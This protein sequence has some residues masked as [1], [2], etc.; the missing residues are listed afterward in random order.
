MRTRRPAEVAEA[1]HLAFLTA[2]AAVAD[3]RSFALK[4]GG[5]L[6]FFFG[7][8]RFSEDIDLDAFAAEP[9]VFSLKVEKA[10]ES[11]NLA[12]L[13]ATLGIRV[14][15]L[16][17]KDRTSTKEKWVIGLSHPGVGAPV[18]TRV[19]ISHR[20]YGLEA[21][22][23]V[24]P[25]TSQAVA[26]YA[27]LPAPLIGHYL[28]GG[29]VIQKIV[30]LQG[31][32]ATQPRDVFDLDHLFRR[33][34]ETVRPSVLDAATLE[35]AIARVYE[36]DSAAYRSKVVSFLDPS[37]RAALDTADAWGSMQ[38]RVVEALEAMLP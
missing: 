2:F 9:G 12:K 15:H 13:L 6:R 31:R 10:F 3:P 37:V 1:F 22:V 14:T 36:I 35:A 33:Y 30:A 4:G 26:A 18:Y 28:P 5:N 34:P 11:L 32:R 38:V 29:A 7:S 16:N 27:P 19:E 20:A 25:V 8:L 23:A 17:P 24:E 21:Y